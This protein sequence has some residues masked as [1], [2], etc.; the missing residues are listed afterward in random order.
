[1]IDKNKTSLCFLKC[2]IENICVM[3]LMGIKAKQMKHAERTA[4]TKL[5][6]GI[7]LLSCLL[8]IAFMLLANFSQATIPWQLTKEDSS[9]KY[10]SRTRI[11]SSSYV[12]GHRWTRKNGFSSLDIQ[13]RGDI[14]VND[15]DTDVISISPGG[16][17]KIKKTTFGNTRA[18]IIESNSKGELIREYYEGRKKVPFNEE[19]RRWLADVLLEVV[20]HTGIGASTR[21]A[22]FYKKGGVNAVISE[23]R[24]IDSN[25]GKGRYFKELLGICSS[26][27]VPLVAEKIGSYITSN[28]VRGELFRTYGDKFMSTPEGA[29]AFFEGVNYMTSNTER[30]SILRSILRKN[31][32]DDD[33]MISLLNVARKMT[34]NTE[35]GAVLRA[36]NEQFPKSEAVIDAYFDVIRGMTSN[37]EKGSVLRDLLREN[38]RS[39]KITRMVLD[40][41]AHSF[42]SNT[43]MGHVLRAVRPKLENNESLITYY[44]KALYPMTSNTEMGNALRPLIDENTIKS[45]E[46]Q[47]EVFKVLRRMS[48]NTE[49]GRVMRSTVKFLGKNA[50][51]DDAFFEALSSMTSNTEK[52][53][54][55]RLVI[56]RASMSKDMSLRILN[57]MRYF[58]S[59]TEIGNIMVALSRVM[60]KN[61]EK[62]KEAYHDAAR[63][64]S[65]NTEYRRVMEAINKD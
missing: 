20:R 13:Y 21:V 30:S 58:T 6:L 17:L 33:A 37:T 61:D 50:Q 32:L 10:K 49:K 28:S 60:P 64:L 42:T 14:K 27:E 34:S 59:N 12:N 25:S 29:K 8:F 35:R 47:L 65:S 44:L 39:E 57:S 52:G 40:A 16:Y 2:Q 45:V 41:T 54:V 5:I 36:V 46:N 38:H 31:K 55:I 26:N 9:K 53:H 3:N 18:I 11:T 15:T 1:M 22:R 51:V 19:G 56:N 63:R 4:Q 62:V 48:S 23:I 7:N 43:E 24:Q